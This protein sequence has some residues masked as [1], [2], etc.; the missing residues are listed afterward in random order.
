VATSHWLKSAASFLYC[1]SKV[2]IHP[3]RRR[4]CKTRTT[5]NGGTSR[6]LKSAASFFYC[7]SKVSI[8][9]PFKFFEIE[10]RERVRDFI[11][12]NDQGKWRVGF[13]N[14]DLRLSQR[15]VLQQG[16]TSSSSELWTWLELWQSQQCNLWPR[17]Q[18]VQ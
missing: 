2:S 13:K 14:Q 17:R 12:E 9:D 10:G 7:K 6:W 3:G 5:T 18:E 11:T 1:K 8:Q 4:W 16:Q 15:C